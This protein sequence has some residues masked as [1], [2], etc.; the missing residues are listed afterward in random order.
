[1]ILAEGVQDRFH[2]A[3]GFASPTMSH[4][5]PVRDGMAP[6]IPAVVHRDGTARVQTV[7]RELTPGLH[8]LL[9]TFADITDVPLLLNTSFNDQAPIVQ[10]PAEAMECYLRTGLDFLYFAGLGLVLS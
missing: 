3:P 10:T 6:H 5:I 8:D 9:T 7:H 4:A 2:C 1:M